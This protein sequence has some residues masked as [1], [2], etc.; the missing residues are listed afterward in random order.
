MELRGVIPASILP[1]DEDLAIDETAYRKHLVWL[2]S[3]PGVTAITCNGHAGEVASLSRNERRRVISIAVETLAH[4]M[5]VISGIYAENHRDARELARDAE[6][7]G[8][9]A[10][11]VL[12][13]NVLAYGA[14]PEVAYRHFAEIA[15]AVPLPLIVFVYPAWTGLQYDS[16]TLVRICTI[17][18]VT[19][20]K[21]W[22]LDVRVHERNYRA[23]KSL[24]RPVALLT[25]F[26]TNLLPALVSGADGILSGHGSV[27]ADMQV[28]L[29][30]AVA[31]GLLAEAHALYE[32]VQ[33]LTAVIYRHPM[34]GMYARMKEH[35]IMLG[36]ELSPAVRPPLTRVSDDEWHE[37]R[38]TLLDTGL[39]AG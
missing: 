12:P 28:R 35:L 25:S 29:F 22:S 38:Q 30:D 31:S 9:D 36:H 7:E 27:I 32:R 17:P 18:H 6:A 11:L 10:L 15:E 13:P 3:I 33:R 23:V 14:S 24:D 2:T 21:E 39:L 4:R 5:P 19:A 37:L 26:S 16:D 20:V 34:V 1:F 8:A